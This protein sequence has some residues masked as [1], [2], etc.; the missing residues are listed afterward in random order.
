MA[1]CV[2]ALWEGPVAI[3]ALLSTV[4]AEP[5]IS[6]LLQADVAWEVLKEPEWSQ[7]GWLL[8]CVPGS[9]SFTLCGLHVTEALVATCQHLAERLNRQLLSWAACC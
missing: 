1:A 2:G 6:G 7:L 3:T 8:T 9:E 5:L 4:N